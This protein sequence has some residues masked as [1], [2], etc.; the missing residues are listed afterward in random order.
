VT[1]LGHHNLASILPTRADLTA[2]GIPEHPNIV[3]L[4]EG[5]GGLTE[6]IRAALGG[7]LI[8][9]SE[10]DP[11]SIRLLEQHYPGVPN[12]GDVSTIDWTVVRE[13]VH[14][15]AGGFPCQDV[16]HAGLGKGLQHGT[17]SG[18]WSEFAR[19][20][21]E[22]R[23]NLVVIENVKGLRSAPAGMKEEV[24][25]DETDSDLQRADGNLGGPEWGGGPVL[26]ALG[27]VLGDL[28]TLGYRA[29][30]TSLRAADVGACHGRE[31]VFIIA[32]P[33]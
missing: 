10:I 9:Y 4:F 32:V 27:A 28:A 11:S 22:T 25:D 20:I 21:F 7:N 24:V 31:R 3:G 12:L 16:S 1:I 14:V 19:G 33:E 18:L 23:P 8:A 30:W 15:M 29:G 17:R 6:G 5:Y 2:L 26:R 13:P